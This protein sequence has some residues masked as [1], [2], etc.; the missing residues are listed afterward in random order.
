MTPE[1]DTDETGAETGPRCLQDSRT[2]RP[3]LGL[4]SAITLM[5]VFSALALVDEERRLAYFV[6]QLLAMMFG[7]AML[8]L[9]IRRFES[10]FIAPLRSL[11]TWAQRMQGG[12]LSARVPIPVGRECAD[13]A[14]DINSLSQQFRL[15]SWDMETQVNKQTERLA[16]K[17]RDLELLYDLAANIATTTDDIDELLTRFLFTLM[18]VVNAQAGTVRLLTPD[19]HMRLVCSVGLD[20]PSDEGPDADSKPKLE[21]L[22]QME[23]IP[24][25]LQYRDRTLGIYNLYGDP[26]SLLRHEDLGGL[27]KSLGQHM[28]MTIDKV[29][30]DQ[31]RTRL[32]IMEERT[33]L[34]HE[35]H[36]S[37]AQTLASMRFQTNMLKDS[38]GQKDEV[39]SQRHMRNLRNTLDEAYTELRELIAHFR[40]PLDKRGLLPSLE[41]LL[42]RFRKQTG[43]L[44]FF[45]LACDNVDL[46]ADIEMQ[47][48][49]IVQESLAN[50]RKHSQAKTVRVMLRCD[51]EE[52]SL[53]IEDDGVGFEQRTA[54]ADAGEHIGLS[55]MHQRAHRVRGRFLIESEPGEGTRV[56]LVFSKRQPQA[57]LRL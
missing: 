41:T 5:M 15:L 40:A 49:R 43:I 10:G 22:E 3:I 4:I 52:Y 7:G 18:D 38:V 11:R 2:L 31:E 17:T 24:V 33:Q 19:G 23:M 21:D 55:I 45:Q 20:E 57:S 16:Q 6:V 25:P 35:L 42:D 13:L 1:A 32:S 44:S 54:E 8:M 9:T 36:D 30:A 27:I 50:I 53:L 12:D 56:T 37:L 46:P 14:H 48:L 28:G 51:E 47:V 34:A 29:N 39:A 26:N